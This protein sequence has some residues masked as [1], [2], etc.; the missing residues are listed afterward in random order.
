M[1][2]ISI[3]QSLWHLH[4][5]YSN[6]FRPWVQKC[7]G[8]DFSS[9][10]CFGVHWPWLQRALSSRSVSVSGMRFIILTCMWLHLIN[11]RRWP[12]VSVFWNVFVINRVALAI[13]VS[14]P[15]ER[16]HLWAT[17]W[18]K[19]LHGR[20]RS[21]RYNVCS[22]VSRYIYGT[23]PWYKPGPWPFA[24]D[25]RP[26]HL[27]W[28]PSYPQSIGWHSIYGPCSAQKPAV[29]GLGTFFAT[30]IAGPD[31]AQFVCGSNI[32]FINSS[33]PVP[34]HWVSFSV[35]DSVS[36]LAIVTG[37][38]PNGTPLYI[39]QLVVSDASSISPADYNADSLQIRLMFSNVRP[40]DIRLFVRSV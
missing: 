34:Y 39:T 5:C 24:V 16:R 27:K 31:G 6:Q 28:D 10:L 2:F 29:T 4:S 13:G 30:R 35:G 33:D 32:Q 15:P 7:S 40:K 20:Q 26:C 23:I 1:P 11:H 25:H 18:R 8:Q 38:W 36:A 22:P 3:R 37:N 9:V 12:G 17:F 19:C 21:A 14:F